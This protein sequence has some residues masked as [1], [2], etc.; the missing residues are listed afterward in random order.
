MTDPTPGSAVRSVRLPDALVA[1]LKTYADKNSMSM[2]ELVR[3]AMDAIAD[4]RAPLEDRTRTTTR[5]TVWVPPARYARFRKVVKDQG[6]TIT[7]AIEQAL[8]GIL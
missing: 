6:I 4:G 2:S 3:E 1:R 8:E 5:I 7:R